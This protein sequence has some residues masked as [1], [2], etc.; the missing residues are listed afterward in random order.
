M[1][2]KKVL[3]ALSHLKKKEA[4]QKN[5]TELQATYFKKMLG[6]E[7]SMLYYTLC[8]YD[9]SMKE[10]DKVVR[11]LVEQNVEESENWLIKKVKA[12]KQSIND[13]NTKRHKYLNRLEKTKKWKI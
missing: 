7:K 8:E 3:R 1:R 6:V 5:T 10:L 12:Y 11:Y 9:I 2:E 4:S 13:L